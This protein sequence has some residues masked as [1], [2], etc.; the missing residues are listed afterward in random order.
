M[1]RP[2][3]LEH[4][5]DSAVG[6]IIMHRG[7]LWHG[8]DVLQPEQSRRYSWITWFSKVCET[9]E[10]DED[11][12]LRPKLPLTLSPTCGPANLELCDDVKKADIAK[13]SRMSASEL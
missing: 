13:F 3:Y 4:G 10:E 5:Q 8:V 7:S 12:F 6:E 11:A 9:D 1:G 2:V